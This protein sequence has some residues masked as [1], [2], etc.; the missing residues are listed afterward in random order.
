MNI[1]LMI[2]GISIYIL[3]FILVVAKQI[4]TSTAIKWTK[5]DEAKPV[6]LLFIAIVMVVAPITYSMKLL[7]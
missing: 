2:M 7:P 5:W 1:F 6:I 3:A 4:T